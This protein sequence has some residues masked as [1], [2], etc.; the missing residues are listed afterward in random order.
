MSVCPF[1]IND[2]GNNK[3]NREHDEN[4]RCDTDH[5]VCPDNEKTAQYKI[6]SKL[7]RGSVI[8]ITELPPLPAALVISD[9]ETFCRDE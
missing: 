4:D 3:S 8:V 9:T 6:C 7:I 2:T 1:A 5:D